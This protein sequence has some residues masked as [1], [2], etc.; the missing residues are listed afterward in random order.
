MAI[1]PVVNAYTHMS[2]LPRQAASQKPGTGWTPAPLPVAVTAAPASAGDALAQGSRN[3]A[4]Q[5][6][7]FGLK[8]AVSDQDR[9]SSARAFLAYTQNLSYNTVQS[10][11]GL[12]ALQSLAQSI[13]SRTQN[14]NAGYLSRISTVA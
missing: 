2:W 9:L 6:F 5:G 4:E 13:V 10:D 11:P 7:L 1:S 8:I 3:A 14:F 12:S